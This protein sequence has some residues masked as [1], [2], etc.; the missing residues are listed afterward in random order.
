MS[1]PRD[2]LRQALHTLADALTGYLDAP[3]AK[4]IRGMAALLA[5]RERRHA[6]SVPNTPGGAW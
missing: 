2:Q 6:P 5:E 3:P 1:D 4:A